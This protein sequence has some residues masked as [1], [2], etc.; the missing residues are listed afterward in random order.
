MRY[1]YA[2]IVALIST[3][4]NFGCHGIQGLRLPTRCI[5][6]RVTILSALPNVV[7]IDPVFTDGTVTSSVHCR[8]LNDELYPLRMECSMPGNVARFQQEGVRSHTNNAFLRFLHDIFEESVLSIRHPV[9]FEE[10]FS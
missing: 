9:L 3:M 4:S 6:E 10:G 7:I 5:Q 8:M 2:W 1:T